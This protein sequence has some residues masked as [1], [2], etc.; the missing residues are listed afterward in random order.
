MDND[1]YILGIHDGH[2]AAAALLKDGRLVGALGEERLTGVKNQVGFPRRAIAELLGLEG[3][4]PRDLT[5]VALGSRFMH[6][7]EY[8]EDIAPWYRVGLDQ[9]RRDRLSGKDYNE[10]VFEERTKARLALA[11]E[12]LDGDVGKVEFVEHHLAHAATAYYGAPWGWDRPVLVFTCDGAGDGLSA[13]V[14]LGRQG[15]L[16]R[17]D[18]TDRRGSLGKIYSRV[19]YL[20]G[21]KPWEHEYKLMGLAPYAGQ[22]RELS[23]GVFE[24]LMTFNDEAG[25]FEL[26]SELETNYCYFYLRDNLENHRFDEIAGGLQDYTEEMLAAWVSHFV[27]RTGIN[28]IVC[29]G[30]VFM[31]VKANGR[32]ARLPGVE[33]IFVCPS[34]GDESL[35]IGAAYEAYHRRYT[36]AGKHPLETLY[37]GPAYD[38]S[39]AETAL[40]EAGVTGTCRVEYVEDIDRL[41]GRLLAENKIVARFQGRMEW[42][43]RAL[44]NR[45][46]LA[47]GIDFQNV[48][49]IN[50]MIKQRDFWMPFAPTILSDRAGDYLVQPDGL[51]ADYMTFALASTARGRQDLA[52]AMHP[53]DKTMRPQV[54]NRETNPRYEQVLRTYERATGR[55]GLLNTSFNLHGYP[56]VCTPAD[57]LRVFAESGLEHLALENWYVTKEKDG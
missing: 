22:R 14:S 43:A 35:A 49:R 33:A 12:H 26:Q 23:R 44:G 46:I 8:L 6:A 50:T 32:L 21:M 25:R 10:A 2:N 40:Q 1:V 45:S 51:Q 20:M 56:I 16:E 36:P 4:A 41:V 18:Q 39:R 13:T 11:A 55:G 47:D 48:A 54:L 15:R 30:G 28:R 31:N 17:I 34:S 53:A 37:L 7:P 24:R 3:L 52:A 29:G 38:N 42:G 27:R 57:A 9:Q 19:T 5:A